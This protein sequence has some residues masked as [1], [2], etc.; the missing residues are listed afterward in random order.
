MRDERAAGTHARRTASLP[1]RVACL[2]G[3]LALG[4]CAGGPEVGLVAD[5]DPRSARIL[6]EN[7]NRSGPMPVVTT[8]T[9]PGGLTPSEVAAALA[10]GVSGGAEF[11][12]QPE[13]QSDGPRVLLLFGPPEQ[14]SPWRACA[15]DAVLG[16]GFGDGRR[17]AALVCDGPSTVAH[18][19]AVAAG[20]TAADATDLLQAVGDRL[21]PDP[22]ERYAYD[23][24]S[25]VGYGG[26]GSFGS[27]GSSVG[28]GIGFGF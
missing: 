9:A 19:R 4:A 5:G 13:A 6:L 23:R 25:G 16:S 2:A 8:G 10:Q 3:L 26:F 17:V 14:L 18:L 22:Y 28:V 12:M 27:Y 21:F 11:T 15:P 20:D 1:L 24:Y 7:V